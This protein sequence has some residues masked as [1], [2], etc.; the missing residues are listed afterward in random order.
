MP[1]KGKDRKSL[2][3]GLFLITLLYFS[4]GFVSILF[5][6]LAGLCM[7]IPFIL[8]SRYK[9]KVWCSTYCPRASLLMQT[10]T[11]RKTRAIGRQFSDGTLKKAMLWYFGLNLLFITGS[12]IQVASHNMASMEYIRLFI[13]IPLVPLPQLITIEAPPAL[14]HLSYRLYSMMLSSTILGI[15]L[16]RMY[17]PRIW[18]AICPVG[19][20]SNELLKK[21]R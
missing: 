19:S 10:G 16:S 20:I 7:A 6:L 5:G 4:L 21:Q 3:P 2:I 18:C 17:R 9:K 12:T 14:L 8:L 11:K 13:A 1:I 15:A